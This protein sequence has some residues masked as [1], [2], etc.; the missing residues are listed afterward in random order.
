M[1]NEQD[2]G[3]LINTNAKPYSYGKSVFKTLFFG[4]ASA[5]TG[6]ISALPSL[7]IETIAASTIEAGVGGLIIGGIVIGGLALLKQEPHVN[8]RVVLPMLY[9]A[10]SYG[11]QWFGCADPKQLPFTCSPSG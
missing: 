8:L 7:S 4:A 5:T 3:M 9:C 6:A 11:H 2:Q 10:T 1:E